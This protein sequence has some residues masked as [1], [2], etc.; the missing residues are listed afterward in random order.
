MKPCGIALAQVAQPALLVPETVELD[1]LL[2]R[3]KDSAWQLA[4]VVDEYGGFAGVVTLEDLIEEIVG[5]V[6]D[7]HDART[8]PIRPSG[9]SRRRSCSRRWCSSS[10]CCRSSPSPSAS[11]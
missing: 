5:E 3:L 10:R 4:V 9:T 7:E 1:V 2:D 6:V 11:T 8:R